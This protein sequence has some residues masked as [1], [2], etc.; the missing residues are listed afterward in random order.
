MLLQAP[1]ILLPRLDVAITPTQMLGRCP[2]G[3]CDPCRAAALPFRSC[4]CCAGWLKSHASL[5]RHTRTQRKKIF[6]EIKCSPRERFSYLFFRWASEPN[7][8]KI[9]S[10]CMWSC[11]HWWPKGRGETEDHA[12]TEPKARNKHCSP[13]LFLHKKVRA[14]HFKIWFFIRWSNLNSSLSLK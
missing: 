1:K 4:F 11:K 2:E 14:S 12:S 5:Q 7:F 9:I 10:A 6:K 3:G 13:P 8:F